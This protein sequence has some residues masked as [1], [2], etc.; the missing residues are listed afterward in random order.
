[1]ELGQKLCG[2]DAKSKKIFEATCIGLQISES[3]HI[4]VKLLTAKGDTKML[5]SAH[6]HETKQKA[7]EFVKTR[8]PIMDEANKI[9]EV[10]GAKIDKMRDEVN[11][12]P[13]HAE[14]AEKIMKGPE[15]DLKAVK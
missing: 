9:A 11:G 1:M 2:Y 10:A 6:V 5:E 13:T 3:G 8:V 14:L 4:L 15:P 7:E 12:P